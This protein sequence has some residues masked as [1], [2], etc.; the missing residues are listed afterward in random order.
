[1]GTER[2]NG[3]HH[4]T[5]RL[6]QSI[7]SVLLLGLGGNRLLLLDCLGLGVLES[8]VSIEILKRE[9]CVPGPMR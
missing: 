3:S 6:V 8:M 4:Q 5:R 1:M 9:G 2:R 7:E